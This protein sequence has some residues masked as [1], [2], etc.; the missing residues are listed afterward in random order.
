[1]SRSRTFRSLGTRNYRLFFFGQLISLIGSWMQTVALAWLVLGITK[2]GTQLGLI[3]AVQFVPT[4]VG[5]MHGGLL[6]DRFD[7]RRILIATQAALAVQ[8]TVLA[9]VALT[10]HATLGVL[11]ALA[12]IQG[13]IITI[14]NP[15]RQAFVSEMVG[16]E[17]LTNAVGLNSAMFNA[18]RIVG[19]GV[20][21]VLIATVGTSTCFVINA[22]SF[23]AVIG[24]LLAMRAA[25]LYPA[26]R[27][28][29]AKGQLREGLRYVWDEPTLR[30]VLLMIAL[31]GTL[32]MNFQ[33]VLP[34]VAKQVFSG[35]AE[36]YGFLSATMAFGSLVGALLAAAR[37]KPTMLLLGA[38]SIAFG[39]S[40]LLDAVAVSLAMEMVALFLTG[41]TSITFM[42]SANATLQLTSRPEMR[43][44]VMAIYMLLFLG[45][46]PIGGPIVGWIAERSS[47]RWS[48]AAGGCACLVA[49]LFAVPRVARGWRPRVTRSAW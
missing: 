21:G 38:A 16:P 31:I 33:V 6:A 25:D 40:M 47:A 34:I 9:T 1:M 4:L 41:I 29:R 14:D 13:C 44:R 19:P 26:M 37:A 35:N 28:E 17:D 49:A 32:A 46:T 7:K 20:G 36:T 10:G 15:T 22:V 43:G 24:G 12:I 18:A 48:L 23:L 39:L 8:A 30:A 5:S 27:A 2:S 42:S 3:V 11:Y 45:S